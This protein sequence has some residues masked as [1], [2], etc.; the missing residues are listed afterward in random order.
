VLAVLACAAT[1]PVLLLGL[2]IRRL[3]GSNV[4]LAAGPSG[5][6]IRSEAP[7]VDNLHLQW[8]EVDR[9][10]IVH[11]RLLD[12]RLVVTPRDPRS[13]GGRGGPAGAGF[14]VRISLAD[15]SSADIVAALR[16]YRAGQ[17][18]R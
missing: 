14:Q 11:W 1:L 17:C 6:W 4:L 12:K 18:E 2:Q 16:H 5:L 13:A 10:S 9:V 7:L 3:T 8:E 15:R